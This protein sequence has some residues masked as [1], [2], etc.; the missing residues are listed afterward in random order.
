LFLDFCLQPI[1]LG[2][3]LGFHPLK[4]PL[5]GLSEGA[6]NFF[7]RRLFLDCFEEGSCGSGVDSV[8]CLLS[9]AKPPSSLYV[10]NEIVNKRLIGLATHNKSGQSTAKD[11]PIRCQ[12]PD[13]IFAFNNPLWKGNSH[14]GTLG[15]VG[16]VILDPVLFNSFVRQPN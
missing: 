11:D 10:V 12:H 16:V 15:T 7:D 2:F 5:I 1:E 6:Y 8:L 13:P 9:A 14:R 4:F 3:G